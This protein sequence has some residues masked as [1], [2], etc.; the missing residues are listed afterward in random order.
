MFS[1]GLVSSQALSAS[2]YTLTKFQCALHG[3]ILDQ[4]FPATLQNVPFSGFVVRA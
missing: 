1:K 3:A 4:L 2:G